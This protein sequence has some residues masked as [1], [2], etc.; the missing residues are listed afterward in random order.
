MVIEG[1]LPCGREVSPHATTV[2]AKAVGLSKT[3][4]TH[5]TSSTSASLANGGLADG[6]FARPLSD[7]ERKFGGI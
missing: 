4:A 1:G 3:L 6:P 7:G 5:G 2:E